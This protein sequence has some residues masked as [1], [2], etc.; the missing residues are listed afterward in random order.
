MQTGKPCR[1]CKINQPR[2]SSDHA[3]ILWG[4]QGLSGQ[5]SKRLSGVRVLIAQN[6][7]EECCHFM[8]RPPHAKASLQGGLPGCVPRA[9]LGSTH[10]DSGSG[11]D[12]SLFTSRVFQ[13]LP[14][15]P[16]LD[17]NITGV[18]PEQVEGRTRWRDEA[19]SSSPWLHWTA[20]STTN[21]AI[22]RSGS[23][24]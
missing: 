5:S 16:T 2:I 9:L 8:V 1:F 19:C 18:R 3:R 11:L 15:F 6:N 4:W 21:I 23:A 12:L 24:D 7:T 14:S 17:S 22:C 10:G 20:R 13:D